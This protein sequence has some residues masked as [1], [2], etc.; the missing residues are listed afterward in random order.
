MGMVSLTIDDMKQIELEI[1]D[2]IH[3]ICI[4]HDLRYFMA[5]G[6]LLGAVRH[7]GFIPWD[8][9]MDALMFRADY[10]RFA[11]NFDQWR[12]SSRFALASY[13]H[14]GAFYPFLK[15][16]DTTT[17]VLENFVRKDRDVGVW[18]DI[19]PYDEVDPNDGALFRKRARANLMYNFIVADPAVGSNALAKLAKRIVCPL[20]GRSDPRKYAGIIDSLSR[21]ACP[22]G[23]SFVADVVAQGDSAHVFPKT[24]FEPVEMPFEDRVYLAPSGYREFLNIQYGDWETPPSSDDRAVHTCEAYRLC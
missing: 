11:E 18:V 17:A 21:E 22:S 7:G 24:L 6:T 19:F 13:R 2:E 14:G 8:D 20:V 15:V 3:R 23:S 9:D 1:F 12:S 10:E 4:E 16:V 5:Y